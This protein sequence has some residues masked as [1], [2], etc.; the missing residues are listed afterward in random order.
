[1]VEWE[2]AESAFSK[3]QD[4]LNQEVRDS[5]AFAMRQQLVVENDLAAE[6]AAHA[7]ERRALR[8]RSGARLRVAARIERLE[9]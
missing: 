8:R 2:K 1:M 3:L 7:A 6:R 5:K 9:K 4:L